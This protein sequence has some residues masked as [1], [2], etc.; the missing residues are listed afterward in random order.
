MAISVTI[1]DESDYVG[2]AAS[3]TRSGELTM[4]SVG[5]MVGKIIGHLTTYVPPPS[6]HGLLVHAM[7]HGRVAMP[8]PTIGT[9]MSRL[10]IL[11]HGNPTSLQLGSDWVSAANFGT[12]M[13]VLLMLKPFFDTGA[14]A[15]LQHCDA[16]MNMPLLERFADAFGVPIVAGQGFQNPV[17][18]FNTGR[19]VRVFPAPPSGSRPASTSSFWGPSGQ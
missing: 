12:Y 2:W 4:T 3:A 14:F 15:H 7:S 11:D 16:G 1:V 8:T 9:K 19:F 6:S 17:Y 18:R 13:P 10:N 5:N